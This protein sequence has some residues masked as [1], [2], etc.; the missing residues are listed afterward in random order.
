[1]KPT[2]CPSRAAGFA[3]R[4]QCDGERALIPGTGAR[5]RDSDAHRP[6]WR[7]RPPRAGRVSRERLVDRAPLRGALAFAGFPGGRSEESRRAAKPSFAALPMTMC[8]RIGNR[9]AAWWDAG[10]SPIRPGARFDRLFLSPRRLRARPPHHRHGAGDAVPGGG[11]SRRP[12]RRIGT[13]LRAPPR[14]RSS[15]ACCSWR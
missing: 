5:P 8:G 9:G 4:S 11:R 2:A 10:P 15:S 3:P 7:K 6:G 13:A 14:H 12:Q 1:M